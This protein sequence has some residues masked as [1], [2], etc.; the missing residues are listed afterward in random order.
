MYEPSIYMCISRIGESSD[1]I[2]V[3]RR[4]PM[5]EVVNVRIFRIERPEPVESMD[6]VWWDVLVATSVLGR[7]QA[8]QVTVPDVRPNKSLV[9]PLVVEPVVLNLA[10]ARR[11]RRCPASTET[12]RVS[13]LVGKA[14][15]V[16]GDPEPRRGSQGSSPPVF[17]HDELFSRVRVP[18]QYRHVVVFVQ[19]RRRVYAQPFMKIL[20]H[21]W[22]IVL[23]TIW[24]RW[25][26][27]PSKMNK[28]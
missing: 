20:K 18:L 17:D 24:K 9:R 27:L 23:V 26:S 25:F 16:D 21:G 14:G 10:G 28:S 19:R 11:P 3:L 13:A 7:Q 5:V 2:P 6:D 12:P 4:E 15:G 1:L 8:P 22:L